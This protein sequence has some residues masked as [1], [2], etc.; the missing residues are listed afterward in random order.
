M[1]EELAFLDALGY[2]RTWAFL[3]FRLHQLA[4]LFE[5]AFQPG[6]LISAFLVRVLSTCKFKS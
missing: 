1:G 6:T 3:A 2:R 5:P 4:F